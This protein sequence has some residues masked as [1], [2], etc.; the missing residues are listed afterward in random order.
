MNSPLLSICIPTYNRAEVLN[1]TLHNLLTNPDFDANKIEIIVSDNCSGDHTAQ[2]VANYPSVQY[3]RNEHNIV[4]RNFT[5]VLN[6]ARGRYIRLFNDTLTFKEGALARMLTIIESEID[7][8]R[9]LFIYGSAIKDAWGVKTLHTKVDF[10]KSV[11]FQSTW[12]ANFGCWRESFE[13]INNKDRSA[14]TQFLQVDW[15]FR[16]VDNGKPTIIY[17]ESFFTVETPKN[18]G[19]YNIFN[20]FVNK[21]LGLVKAEGLP[22]MVYEFEKYRLFRYFVFSWIYILLINSKDEYCFETRN[23]WNIIFKKYWYEPYLYFLL[24]VLWMKK[25]KIIK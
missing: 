6:H 18:K 3:L 23:V 11:S 19:G 15:S 20:T 17:S 2:V 13:Q 1:R 10:L 22:L 21:Y 5:V 25:V 4:D 14:D 9:N 16:I 12:I 7:K 8:N 24:L